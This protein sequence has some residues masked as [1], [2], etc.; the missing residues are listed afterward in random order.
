MDRKIDIDRC[1]YLNL[2]MKS[3][4][5]ETLK[6]FFRNFYICDILDLA[7]IG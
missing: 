1:R 6:L 4:P 3:F 7:K 5:N 2:K